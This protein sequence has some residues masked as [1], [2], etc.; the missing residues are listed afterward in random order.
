MKCNKCDKRVIYEGLCS[1]CLS[2]EADNITSF[3][4]QKNLFAE[5]KFGEEEKDSL[6]TCDIEITIK[7]P[8]EYPTLKV[9]TGDVVMECIQELHIGPSGV[10]ISLPEIESDLIDSYADK[11][12][13]LGVRVTRT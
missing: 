2:K 5:V 9:K 1:D 3:R 6:G 7:P 13:E 4:P 8:F 11:L 12:R 10:C